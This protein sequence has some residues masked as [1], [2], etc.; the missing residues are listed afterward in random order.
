MI[1]EINF[2]SNTYVLHVTVFCVQQTH[3]TAQSGCGR[4]QRHIPVIGPF[5]RRWRI[6]VS[7][8]LARALPSRD[9]RRPRQDHGSGNLALYLQ[10]CYR[11]YAPRATM[12]FPTPVSVTV[13]ST[14]YIQRLSLCRSFLPSC[15]V[16]SPSTSLVLLRHPSAKSANRAIFGVAL[17]LSSSTVPDA[18][19]VL[20]KSTLVYRPS[21]AISRTLLRFDGRVY[22]RHGSLSNGK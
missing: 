16:H 19:Y 6:L 22:I 8:T 10:A 9:A 4:K 7:P 11:R 3:D 18:P 5:A 13:H 15:P 2:L 1:G 20:R 14:V 17:L 12:S 21:P